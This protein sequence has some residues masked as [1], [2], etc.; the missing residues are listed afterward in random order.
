MGKRPFDVVDL[1]GTGVIIDLT[2]DSNERPVKS[3]NEMPWIPKL[4]KHDPS[5]KSKVVRLSV[6]DNINMRE[7]RNDAAWFEDAEL[8]FKVAMAH[9][10]SWGCTRCCGVS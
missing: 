2:G 3:K 10:L 5:K 6:R 7:L 4:S 8:L 9:P 1:T